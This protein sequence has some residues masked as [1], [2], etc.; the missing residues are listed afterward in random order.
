MRGI[1]RLSLVV[2][3]LL[4]ASL[5]V[6]VLPVL[7]DTV[8]VVQR[9]DTLYSISRRFG[10]SMWEI[11]R[12]NGIADVNR[13]WAGQVLRI[14]GG[15]GPGPGPGPGPEPGPSPWSWGPYYYPTAICWDGWVSHAG[16][17]WGVCSG[18]GGVRAWVPQAWASTG[19]IMVR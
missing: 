3:I 13:I 6:G 16:Y 4:V 1:K 11:A 8:Y 18:H 19:H 2:V 12:L 14:P 5:L 17:Y 9:G 7:A 15:G 10:V